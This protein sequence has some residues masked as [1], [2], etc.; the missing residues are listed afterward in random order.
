VGVFSESAL[1]SDDEVRNNLAFKTYQP[2]NVTDAF[3]ADRITLHLRKIDTETGHVS[4]QSL[5]EELASHIQLCTRT[6]RQSGHGQYSIL[7]GFYPLPTLDA[8]I[9]E[10][11]HVYG[12][13]GLDLDVQWIADNYQSHGWAIRRHHDVLCYSPGYI[14]K[15]QLRHVFGTLQ[16]VT[17][18]EGKIYPLTA[19]ITPKVKGYRNKYFFMALLDPTDLEKLQLP[20][21]HAS[22]CVLRDFPFA[23]DKSALTSA[24][25]FTVHNVMNL[26]T[27]GCFMLVPILNYHTV[28]VC[29]NRERA[30]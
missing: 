1:L 6:D 4:L 23:K 24:M 17:K 18:N 20:T 10:L 25:F 30:G 8:T 29:N 21:Q 26:L 19:A 27:N 15:H 9:R 28:R 16:R 13:L 12:E 3:L 2:V 22:L 7:C 14:I 11:Q 5:P